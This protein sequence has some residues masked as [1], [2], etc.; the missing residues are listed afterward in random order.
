M[1]HNSDN[2]NNIIKK[3]EELREKIRYHNYRYYVLDDPTDSDAEYDR[4]MKELA[5]WEAKYPLPLR[6]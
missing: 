5:D 6:E 1:N 4:L 2:H 3:I